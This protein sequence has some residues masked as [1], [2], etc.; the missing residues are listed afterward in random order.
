[1]LRLMIATTL[2]VLL[3]IP[4]FAQVT[5]NIPEPLRISLNVPYTSDKNGPQKL[6]IYSQSDGKTPRPTVI[7]FHGAGSYKEAWVLLLVPYLEMGWNAVNVEYSMRPLLRPMAPTAT[8]DGLCAL[9]WV[10]KNS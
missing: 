5:P 1:M 7:F 6:D 10:V 9:R 4:L 8:E 2:G 3:Q